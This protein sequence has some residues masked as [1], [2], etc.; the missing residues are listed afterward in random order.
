MDDVNVAA[1]FNPVEN[2]PL[3]ASLQG[4]DKVIDHFVK[5]A[6]GEVLH[7]FCSY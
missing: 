7:I 2:D 4:I 3:L 5:N 6:Q 1:L